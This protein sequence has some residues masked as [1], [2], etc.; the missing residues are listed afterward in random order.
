MITLPDDVKEMLVALDVGE[1]PDLEPAL[2]SLHAAQRVRRY[3]R[4]KANAI[5]ARKAGRI[6]DA[7]DAEE[8]CDAIYNLLPDDWKW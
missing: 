2:A 3:I 1:V 4:R 8:E 5:D 7:M 6:S